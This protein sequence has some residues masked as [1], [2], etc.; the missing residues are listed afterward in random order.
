MSQNKN[1]LLSK[2]MQDGLLGGYAGYDVEAT[3]AFEVAQ[4]E[5][6]HLIG[7]LALSERD[8]DTSAFSSA[9][10][11]LGE[12]LPYIAENADTIK[13]GGE[14]L[15]REFDITPE[16]FE[17]P[18]HTLFFSALAERSARLADRQPTL[19]KEEYATE[20]QF[21]DDA[22]MMLALKR[23][24]RYEEFKTRLDTE[25]YED[26]RR[27]EAVYDKFTNKQVSADFQKAIDDGLFDAVK[28]RL[29][30]RGDIKED[31][32]VVRV[33]NVGENTAFFGMYPSAEGV[34]VTDP[35]F[36]DIEADQASF[37]EY[38][39]GL[40]KKSEE[41]K[42]EANLEKIPLAW[43]L[44]LNGK[45][46][47]NIPLP[48]AEKILYSDQLRNPHYTEP[49]RRSDLAIAEHEFTH[50]EGGLALDHE[51]FYGLAVEERRAEK[52]SGDKNGYQ[53][54]KGFMDIDLTLL[55]GIRIPDIIEQ[56]AKGGDP[57]QLFV[58]MASKIGLQRTLE[59]A[60]TVP[61]SYLSDVR[62]AQKFVNEYLGGI[63]GL[64]TRIYAD[65]PD[66]KKQ[67]IEEFI[68][69]WAK[70][71]ADD[72]SI[73]SWLSARKN[74][75]GLEF[76]TQKLQRA[77]DIERAQAKAPQEVAKVA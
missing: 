36:K 7:Q 74:R 75:H 23:S 5:N 73:D 38:K 71:K 43:M 61:H 40:L 19:S 42:K 12:Q 39:Q 24:N 46:S 13:R 45:G 1:A 29:R 26:E 17:K 53:E 16:L 49:A 69:E 21:I 66:H 52:S 33:L 57:N 30:L 18:A 77:L 65:H 64:E 8:R 47:L 2:P 14:S 41:F 11:S 10:E 76:V 22:T 70:N 67:I 55:T 48:I 27:T 32:Y 63:N 62:P 72:A 15:I 3:P 25:G 54:V 31:P 35:R 4:E 60:L 51:L 37:N 6:A 44:H 9:L 50:A 20:K 58:T 68:G 28:E 34:P 59:F 56:S